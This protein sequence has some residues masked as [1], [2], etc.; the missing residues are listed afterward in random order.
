MLIEK[1]QENNGKRVLTPEQA[2]I[3]RDI[4]AKYRAGGIGVLQGKA[5]S[6]KTVLIKA[7]KK[8]CDTNGVSCALTASTGKAGSAIGGSTIHSYLGLTMTQNDSAENVE[9]A[10]VL[11]TRED[12]SAEDPDILIIDEASMIGQK[13]LREILAREFKYIL[14]V[15]D[16]NQL[17]PV[18]DKKVEWNLIASSYYEL[19]KT[20]RAKDP[21][22]IQV[23]EDFKL[24]KEGELVDLN[25]FDY[26]NGR[27]IVEVDYVDVD[28]MPANTECTFVG[29]RNKLVEQMSKRLTAKDHKLMNLNVGVTI[30][31]MVVDKDNPETNESGYF[32]REFKS[33]A[34]FFNG[35][36]VTIEPIPDVTQQLVARGWTKYGKWHL[37]LTKNGIIVTD[38]TAE[39]KFGD[40]ES[41]DPK[42]YIS[43]PQDEVLEYCTLSIIED[44]T[45]AL[46][47]DGTEDEFE[48]MVEFY[49][50]E[51][52][53][54]LNKFNQIKKYFKK[55]KAD[56]S[57]LDAES[58]KKI[59]EMTK[60]GF[61]LWYESHN[62]TYHRKNGWKN[63]L[64]AKKVVSARPT[65]ARTIH[66]SQGISV[67]AVILSSDSFYGASKDA[68]YVAVSRA[69]HGI[70]LIKDVPTNW[71][72]K[73]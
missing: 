22:L 27:N 21:E 43:F 20:L 17:Q 3:F 24:Q 35:E 2:S 41:R 36:D 8:Y 37:K 18:K 11:G 13:M 59:Q 57:V 50:G 64:N 23:F 38:S 10:F 4:V 14:F 30:T 12:A 60:S 70:I 40:A 16:F 25:I 72:D 62:D 68:Q 51:L 42:F 15:G 29:Y 33:F 65:T 7:I 73:N 52:Y 58:R 54:Y 19:T 6:G 61:M 32:N 46:V 53:P 69:K 1:N 45:F 34:K 48:G 47:W 28:T 5:G 55:E 67:P 26:I 71:K 39:V 31:A 9:D 66:K 63:L 56:I 44:D 49:F